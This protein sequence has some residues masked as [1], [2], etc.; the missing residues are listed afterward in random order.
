MPVRAP[1][2][3]LA[4]EAAGPQGFGSAARRPAN[5]KALRHSATA[6]F[7]LIGTRLRNRLNRQALHFVLQ[8]VATYA[9]GAC[10]DNVVHTGHSNRGFGN[11]WGQDNPALAMRGKD[12]LLLSVLQPAVALGCSPRRKTQ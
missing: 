4:R 6:A 9:C 8:R 11:I 12:L 5:A 10:I 3:V 1:P 2:A 7:A